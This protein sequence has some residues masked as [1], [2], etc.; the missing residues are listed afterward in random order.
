MT[1]PCWQC[2]PWQPC[3]FDTLVNSFCPRG[4]AALVPSLTVGSTWSNTATTYSQFGA[5]TDTIANSSFFQGQVVVGTNSI[6]STAWKLGSSVFNSINAGSS[7]NLQSGI[8]GFNSYITTS[9][10]VNNLSAAA[11]ASA[12]GNYFIAPG[13]Y[14][15]ANT[16]GTLSDNDSALVIGGN[17]NSTVTTNSIYG[18]GASSNLWGTQRFRTGLA[19]KP[20]KAQVQ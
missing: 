19:F 2:D 3:D 14:L 1:W 17:A 10:G 12:I 7:I 13:S 11:Y 20:S 6:G 16:N 4:S 15:S 18:T 9:S 5:G 8:L